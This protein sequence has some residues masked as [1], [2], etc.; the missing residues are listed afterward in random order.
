MQGNTFAL[1]SYGV[2]LR[3]LDQFRPF[4]ALAV[5]DWAHRVAGHP[6]DWVRPQQKIEARRRQAALMVSQLCCCPQFCHLRLGWGNYLFSEFSNQRFV[7]LV[8]MSW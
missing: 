3:F 2:E 6:L 4:A 1:S 7:A 8:F 5:D